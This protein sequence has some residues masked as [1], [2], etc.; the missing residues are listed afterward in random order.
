MGKSNIL[1]FLSIWSDRNFHI[2]DQRKNGSGDHD[3]SMVGDTILVS[4]DGNS[5]PRFPSSTSSKYFDTTV[6]QGITTS[7]VSKNE[8]AGS[9]YIREAFRYIKLPPEVTIVILE[10]WQPS[11][12]SRYESLFK[13][14]HRYAISRNEDPYSSDVNTVLTF[15]H[16]MYTVGYVLLAVHC[17]VS[18]QLG[19]T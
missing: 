14:G 16:G 4:D 2:K 15:M 3:Y 9:S 17:P 19:D 18:L 1:C 5:S 12:T 6:Q 7:L 8:T 10:S 13:R 11:T